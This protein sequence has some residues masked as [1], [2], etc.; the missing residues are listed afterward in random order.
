MRLIS[1][2]RAGVEPFE[3][4]QAHLRTIMPSLAAIWRHVKVMRDRVRRYGPQATCRA[5]APVFQRLEQSLTWISDFGAA[6][7]FKFPL[8]V[9]ASRTHSLVAPPLWVE[10]VCGLGMLARVGVRESGTRASP[11]SPNQQKA[12]S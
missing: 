6:C 3:H 10:R 1:R 4:A 7:M 11:N 9:L 2:A 12:V 8:I 5:G